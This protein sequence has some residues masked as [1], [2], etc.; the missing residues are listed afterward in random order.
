MK[1]IENTHEA[2]YKN[3][4]IRLKNIIISPKKEW[5]VILNEKTSNNDIVSI[6]SFPLIGFISILTFISYSI[7]TQEFLLQTALKKVT[8]TF[9]SLFG[10]LYGAFLILKSIYKHITPLLNPNS[11]FKIIAYSSSLIYVIDFAII[12]I[13]EL[14]IFK[15][16]LLYHIII[17]WHSLN[18]I[19]I[20]QKSTKIWISI[21]YSFII[22]A[23]PEIISR[24]SYHFVKF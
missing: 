22:I 6:F 24:I 4:I 19:E 20:K 16:I 21:F 8:L 9:I 3:L 13:P 7:E 5:L 15:F 2:S 23:T 11:I 1:D 14:F 17:I 12:I 18:N 10:G